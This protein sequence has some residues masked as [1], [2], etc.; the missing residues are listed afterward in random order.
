MQTLENTWFIRPYLCSAD[1]RIDIVHTALYNFTKT[2]FVQYSPDTL[3]DCHDRGGCML[4]RDHK[5]QHTVAIDFREEVPSNASKNLS[6]R[7]SHK[8]QLSVLTLS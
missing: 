5:E 8:H 4:I 3:L 7:V 6:G 2:I 1:I